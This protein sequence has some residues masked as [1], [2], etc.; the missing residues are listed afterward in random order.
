[1]TP[2]IED[3]GAESVSVPL[4]ALEHVAYCPRQAALIHLEATWTE[5]VDTV[6]GDLLHRGVDL[7]A[8]HRRKDVVTIRSL[9]VSSKVYGLHGVCDLVEILGEIAAPIEYKVG[10]YRPGGPADVQVAGQAVCLREAGF[11]VP[12]GYVYS[13]IDRRRHEV[14]ISAELLDQMQDAASA[15]RA[16]LQ[17]VELPRAYHDA[18]CRRCSLRHDCLPELT[19]RVRPKVDLFAPRPLGA[20]H[21]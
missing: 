2:P 4:S 18:R 8:V 9:P 15:M 10:R 19:D 20:W 21:D 13:A 16:I 7:P 6:R 1:M 5:S 3:R 17:Q 11:T 14:S 12:V